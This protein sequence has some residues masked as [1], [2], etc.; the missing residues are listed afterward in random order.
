MSLQMIKFLWNLD[1]KSVLCVERNFDEF[2][3]MVGMI[4]ETDVC[5]LPQY[6]RP[7]RKRRN[8]LDLSARTGGADWFWYNPRSQKAII[9]HQLEDLGR[10]SAP[11]QPVSLSIEL[12]HD[13]L[14][15]GW[16]EE[17][18]RDCNN[19]EGRVANEKVAD[20]EAIGTKSADVCL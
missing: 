9:E 5:R 16:D 20:G 11:V 12:D 1:L 2:E 14:Y 15:T 17:E 8:V 10:P 13:V 7:H 4:D 18:E 6:W 19:S 3:Y